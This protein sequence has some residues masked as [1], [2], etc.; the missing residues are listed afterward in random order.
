MR[1]PAQSGTR[2]IKAAPKTARFGG[3]A[4]WRQTT[5]TLCTVLADVHEECLQRSSL[6]AAIDTQNDS[7]EIKL[8]VFQ[9][10]FFLG[11]PRLARV[12]YQNGRAIPF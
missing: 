3:A 4:P 5:A 7:L 8:R 6:H 10:L 9:Q 2:S 12:V 1:G 11:F